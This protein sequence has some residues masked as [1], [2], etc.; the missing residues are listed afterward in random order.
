MRRPRF[1]LLSLLVLVSVLV[2]SFLRGPVS[3]QVRLADQ[4]TKWEYKSIDAHYQDYQTTLD[5]LNK[6]G[7]EGWELSGVYT[8]VYE[9]SGKQVRSRHSMILKRPKR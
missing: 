7:D 6:E 4:R 8:E 2:L 5:S 9:D 3:A 1:L